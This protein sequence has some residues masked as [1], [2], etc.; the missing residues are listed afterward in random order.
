MEEGDHTVEQSVAAKVQ[1]EVPAPQ[2]ASRSAA[3]VLP[4]QFLAQF[5]QQMAA[6]F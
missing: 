1:G 4:M 2:N 5:A 3:P 6:L